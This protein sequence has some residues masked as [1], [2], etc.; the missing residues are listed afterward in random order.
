MIYNRPSM[1]TYS[2]APA[3]VTILFSLGCQSMAPS[4]T[5]SPT[6]AQAST[7]DVG[8]RHVASVEAQRKITVAPPAESVVDEAAIAPG[9]SIVN[10]QVTSEPAPGTKPEAAADSV[11]NL[12]HDQIPTK[13]PTTAPLS[14]SAS[15]ES[16][17]ASTPKS[18]SEPATSAET[19]L[20]P[21]AATAVASIPPAPAVHS[22]AHEHSPGVSGD[23][24]LK[25]LV[26][27]NI[28]Y[29]KRNY[30]SDGKSATDRKRVYGGQKPHA[31]ILS[32]A[33]SRVPPEIIFDQALGEIFV[34]RVAGEALDS[35]VIASVEYAVEHLGSRLLVVLGH[36]KCGAVDT[37]LKIKE[38]TSAGSADLDKLLADIRPRIKATGSGSISTDLVAESTQ[39]AE[40]VAHDL[41]TRSEI[42]R[43]KV[44]D[45]ELLIKSGL[46]R[47]DSGKVNFN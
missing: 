12:N 16:G 5:V 34:V 26:N 47:L 31:I 17:S 22:G 43:K 3:V 8:I 28:R 1:K 15:A 35:S 46:Y 32:C 42:I 9:P 11:H 30:R 24:S 36:S 2:L 14:K 37:A 44:A 33:D 10:G 19:K 23:L 45:G 27:G 7:T 29:V 21:P 18:D 25:W 38:G 20:A 39:N 6:T 41:L 4:A 13:G 40:G